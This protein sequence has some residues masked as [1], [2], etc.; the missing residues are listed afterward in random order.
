MLTSHGGV[1]CVSERYDDEVVDHNMVGVRDEVEHGRQDGAETQETQY[2][3]I[4]LQQT[5]NVRGVFL[6]WTPSNPATL[7]A[8]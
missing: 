1:Q 3:K 8:S 7:G 5:C 4:H 2:H 6:K